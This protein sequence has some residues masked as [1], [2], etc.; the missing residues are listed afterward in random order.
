MGGHFCIGHR[1]TSSSTPSH[2]RTPARTRTHSRFRRLPF[3]SLRSRIL[4]QAGRHSPSGLCKRICRLSAGRLASCLA[5]SV[6]SQAKPGYTSHRRTR[7]RSLLIQW[8]TS[9]WRPRAYV[10][11]SKGQASSLICRPPSL[12]LQSI[13]VS[14]LPTYLSTSWSTLVKTFFH[15]SSLPPSL[16]PFNH[17]TIPLFLQGKV[18]QL[19]LPQ[20]TRVPRLAAST[21]RLRHHDHA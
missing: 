19:P 13:L 20:G 11:S 1:H 3:P 10:P 12:L 8:W 14:C 21:I 2:S 15:A 6:P 16:P 9:D 7:E 17:S 18:Y 5:C 4:S